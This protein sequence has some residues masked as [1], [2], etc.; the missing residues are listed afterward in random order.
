M[1]QIDS[2]LEIEK[3]LKYGRAKGLLGKWDVVPA[4]NGIM[5]L[6]NI[7]EPATITYRELDCQVPDSPQQILDNLLDY[8]A[9]E[10]ILEKNTI[11]YRDLFDT[12][13]MGQLMPRQSEVAKNFWQIAKQDS[14][15]EATDNYYS[16]SKNSN[17]IRQDRIAKNM[18]WTTATEYGDLE[19]TINLSK[20]EKDPEAIAD[21]KEQE[22]IDYPSCYLCLDN[23]GYPGR[24]DHPARQ[25]HRVIPLTLE[26]EE[27][28]LQYSPYVYYDEHCIV[29]Y[30]EHS[31]MSINQKT[32]ATLFDFVDQIPH[33]FLGSNADL[34]LVGGSIL[35]HD[36]FQGGNHTFPMEKA[37][38]EEEFS[39]P[40]FPEVKVGIVNWPMSVV[41]LKAKDTNQLVEL[42]GLI[43]RTWKEYSD[44]ERD[45]KAYSNGERHNT[46]TPIARKKEDYF[47]L[48]L[49]LRN[50]RKSEQYPFGIFHPHKGLHHIKKENIG[51]IEVMGRAI[52]P[53]R[54]KKELKEIKKF[55]TGER[56]YNKNIVNDKLATHN[57][58]IEE[59]L[60]VYGSNL[61]ENK[62]QE[63]L[64]TEVGKKFKQVLEDA[65]VY[66]RNKNGEQGFKTFFK[67]VGIK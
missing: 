19:I 58:W 2:T 5:D 45:I 49:V 1:S 36:H 38:T 17:Y 42:G 37:K 27:W 44:L 60:E 32:F 12:K 20:P 52:L 14:M 25:T 16:L 67:E 30:K 51:L 34:P 48:D 8:A 41:R 59:M 28:F 9:Q 23:V 50:N 35:N 64:E 4:R 10:E 3:L 11:T 24:L 21:A 62:A 22:E 47:E 43:H 46:V 56:K 54:L 53:G 65:G 7:K 39:H 18:S 31:P 33:Y 61:T 6:L 13:I 63:I 26:N 15:K 66:K 55:L 29:F 40:D 57:N